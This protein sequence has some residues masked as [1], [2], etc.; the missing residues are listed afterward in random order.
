MLFRSLESVGGHLDA[1]TGRELTCFDA[2]ALEEH[3]DLSVEVLADLVLNP[4]LAKEDVEK[5]KKVVLDEIHAYEDNPDERVH[6]LFADVVWSGHPLGNRILGARESVGAFTRDDVA[7]YHER[8]Y[9]A[10]RILIAIAGGTA[11]AF[12]H[13]FLPYGYAP[14]SRIIRGGTR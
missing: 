6:D 11:G 14:V 12:V 7:R 3:L 8:H 5:E 13:A 9:V 10:P 4:R 1:F 2:R